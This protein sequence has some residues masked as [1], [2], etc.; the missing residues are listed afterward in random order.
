M[1]IFLQSELRE[2]DIGIRYCGDEFAAILVNT[3]KNEAIQIA[4]EIHS[5]YKS[6]ILSRITGT[7]D[8]RIKVSIGIALYPENSD[9]SKKLVDIA[10]NKMRKA[11]DMGG[12]SIIA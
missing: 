9:N 12:S 6:M 7:D 4:K 1:A 2:N 3:D 5:T 10:Y 11:R 8:L